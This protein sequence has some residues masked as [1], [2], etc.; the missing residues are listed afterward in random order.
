MS[1]GTSNRKTPFS[2]G[3]YHLSSYA[4]TPMIQPGVFY[5]LAVIS[6]DGGNSGFTTKYYLNGNELTAIKES[7]HD[8]C[9]WHTGSTGELRIGMRNHPDANPIPLKGIL[10]EISIY[11][12]VL[13][14]SEI[15]EI[16]NAGSAGKCKFIEIEIDIKPGSDPN[17]INCNNNN[18]VIPVAILTTTDFDA[19]TVDHETVRFGKTG[20]EAME[21]HIDKKTGELKRHEEDVDGDGD[22]DLV[23]HFCFGETG[24]ECGDREAI[25]T[26]ET[27]GGQTIKGSDAIRTIGD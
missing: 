25:L 24:I 14:Q 12:R 6:I 27:Y 11:D 13:D 18:S 4:E 2:S 21:T 20:A 3:A 1:L 17:S 7:M 23:F 19:M 15:Q 5:H 8:N 16:Y 9:G 26:G 10:D 22:I